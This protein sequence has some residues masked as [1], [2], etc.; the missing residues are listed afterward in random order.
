MSTVATYR[1]FIGDVREQLRILP[2]ASAHCVIT[3][4]PYWNLRQYLPPDHPAKAQEIGQ[5]LTPQDYVHHLV[6]VFR[7][8]RR[9][10]RPDGTV[11]LNLADTYS[12]GV[13]SQ[14]PSD[15]QRGKGSRTHGAVTAAKGSGGAG[16][17]DR[18]AKNLLGIPWRV[19]LALQ[20]DGWI[21]RS[22]IIWAKEN[23]LPESVKDRP[24]RSHEYIFLLAQA[25]RYYYNAAAIAEPV[26]FGDNG[27]Y[28]D[29][30]KTEAAHPHQ[31]RDQRPKDRRRHD[32]VG[33]QKYRLVHHGEPGIFTGTDRRNRRDVWFISTQPYAGSHYAAWPERLVELMVLAGCP[34]GGTVLDPFA[35]SGTTLA[36]AN[37]LGRHAIG[38]DI[39]P[40]YVPLIHQ[41]C[42]QPGFVWASDG[43]G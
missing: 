37:R 30:G 19:A 35:G 38:I 6:E 18:L 4:P 40:E 32:A 13:R 14:V 10:L 7:E 12:R 17:A 36:V 23:P 29:R 9:V 28:F 22:D 11:W 15:T 5:E 25:P 41:R 34:E 43:G 26:R 2:A 20:D 42:Q 1:V 39:N 8:I 31:G 16:V 33:G 3:S 24:T 21:L 27:S